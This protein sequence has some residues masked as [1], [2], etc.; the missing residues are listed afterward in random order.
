MTSWPLGLFPRLPLAPDD[1]RKGGEGDDLRGGWRGAPFALPARC[2]TSRAGSKREGTL[3]SDNVRQGRVLVLSDG[4][5]AR[6][7]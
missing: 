5:P 1:C 3:L 6:L 2:A 7:S 4:Q